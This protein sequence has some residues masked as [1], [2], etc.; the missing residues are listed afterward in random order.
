MIASRK[1]GTSLIDLLL[2]SGSKDHLEIR[3]KEE[4]IERGKDQN[5]RV[6]RLDNK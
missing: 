2:V 6:K 5:L 4:K 1:I 3:Y